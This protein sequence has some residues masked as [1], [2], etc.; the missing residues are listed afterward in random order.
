MLNDL[1][2]TRNAVEHNFMNYEFQLV[3]NRKI[4]LP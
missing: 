3:L 1:G 2:I 4:L